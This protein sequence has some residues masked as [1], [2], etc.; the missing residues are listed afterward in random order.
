VVLIGKNEY[1]LRFI[2]QNVKIKILIN[3]FSND[4]MKV[5]MIDE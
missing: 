1:G 4:K 2:V 5:S 3:T